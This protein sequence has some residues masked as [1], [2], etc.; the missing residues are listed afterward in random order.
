VKER[1]HNVKGPSTA[2]PSST[3]V[4]TLLHGD[5]HEINLVRDKLLATGMDYLRRL[6]RISRRDRIMNETI[7]T[8]MELNKGILQEVEEQQLR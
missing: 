5:M 7:R 4:L 2:E 8:D 1:P 3:I 6:G